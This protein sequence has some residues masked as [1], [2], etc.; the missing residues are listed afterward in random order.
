MRQFTCDRQELGVQ[1]PAAHAVEPARAARLPVG[2]LAGQGIA[3]VFAAY[4]QCGDI[5]LALVEHSVPACP[6]YGSAAVRYV[7]LSP[8]ILLSG[9][10]W[11]VLV[12][13]SRGTARIEPM[14]PVIRA[15]PTSNHLL[16]VLPRGGWV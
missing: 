1:A 5:G 10:I 9:A 12:Q 8:V 11:Q 3:P 6:R 7:P 4:S 14:L 13:P 15:I 16:G 2:R